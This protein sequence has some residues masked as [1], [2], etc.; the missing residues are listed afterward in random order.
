MYLFELELSPDKKQGTLKSERDDY[1]FAES[2]PILSAVNQD[3][4]SPF[5][6]DILELEL[7]ARTSSQQGKTL[8]GAS[9]STCSV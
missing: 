3:L 6:K 8:F 5:L 7:R 9:Y 2:K 4:W 1:K